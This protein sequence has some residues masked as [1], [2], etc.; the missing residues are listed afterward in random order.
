MDELRLWNDDVTVKSYENGGEKYQNAILEQYK[1]CVE[2]HDRVSNRRGLTNTFFLT[3]NTGIFTVFGLFWKDK[4]SGSA[5]LLLLPLV[6]ALIQCAVWSVLIS[7][8]RKLRSAKHEIIWKL[9]ERLP[10]TPLGRSEWTEIGSH[11]NLQRYLPVT[12]LEHSVPLL[13]GLIYVMGFAVAVL[14]K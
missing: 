1:L 3:L 2:M 6:I 9:E 13:F 14:A 11:Q 5:W 12:N 8:Y 4:P 10:A 7:S